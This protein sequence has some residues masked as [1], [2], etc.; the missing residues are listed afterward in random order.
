MIVLAAVITKG[1]SA[2][3]QYMFETNAGKQLS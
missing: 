3:E 2:I 1:A